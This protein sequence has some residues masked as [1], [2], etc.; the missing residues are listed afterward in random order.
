MS[1][2]LTSQNAKK[3][4]FTLIE[5]LVVI[6]IIAILA[7]ILFPVFAQ[8]REKARQASCMSNMNQMGKSTM[9]YVQDYDE[10]FYAHRY[11]C[12]GGSGTGKATTTCPAYLDG[13]G[14]V[15]PE[16]ANLDADS[17]KRY[18]WVYILQPYVKNYQV[19]VCPSNPNA[20]APN[21]KATHIFKAPGA[22]GQNYG[23]ENSYGHNDGW[24]SPAGGFAIGGQPASVTMGGVPRVS[25]TIL[26]TDATYY[27]VDPDV[28][29][30]ESGK[31]I[32]EHCS[33]GVDCNVERDYLL[34]QNQNGQYLNYWKNIGNGDWSYNNQTVNGAPAQ[35]FIDLGKTRHSG[36]IN[37]QFVDGHT[38]ALAYD[39]IIGDIC[40]WTTDADGPHPNCN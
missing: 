11:N 22:V 33:N 27:G 17:L 35:H 16:A 37:A 6:A 23:G 14:N 10:T 8:A 7:A 20:F 31:S 29:N 28:N 26:I 2:T 40:Y 38:K 4:G 25:S 32:L 9:M 5:L 30:N 39:K 21:N 19:F 36:V 13:N 24:M 12:D 15:V 3:S 1:N 18:Y 34:K